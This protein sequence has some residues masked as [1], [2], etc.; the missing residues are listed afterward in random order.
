M[1]ACVPWGGCSVA[2]HNLETGKLPRH[3]KAC[4]DVKL[5]HNNKLSVI[6]QLKVS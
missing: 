6:R 2:G 3:Y 1:T 5:N 4:V